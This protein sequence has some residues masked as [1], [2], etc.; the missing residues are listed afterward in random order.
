M[1]S[2]GFPQEFDSSA[3]RADEEILFQSDAFIRRSIRLSPRCEIVCDALPEDGMEIQFFRWKVDSS[4]D[5]A[6]FAFSG[7]STG[8]LSDPRMGTII[9]RGLDSETP[10]LWNPR[11][12]VVGQ[13]DR[14]SRLSIAEG[15]EIESWWELSGPPALHLQLSAPGDA[16]VYWPM[17]VFGDDSPTKVSD[18]VKLGDIERQRLIKSDWFDAA[19]VADLWAYFVDGGVYDP[20]DSGHGRVRC[21]QCAFAWW[22]YLMGLHRMTM[23]PHYRAFA[24]AVAWSVCVDLGDADS[25]RHGFWH[26]EP[27]VHSGLLWDGVR[28]LLSEYELAPHPDLLDAAH[29][30][31]EFAVENLTDDLEGGSLWFLH[32]SVE[33]SRR[34]HIRSPVI[35]RSDDNSLCLNT[36]VQALC[37]L[38]RINRLAP[39]DGPFRGEQQ[40]AMSALEAAL[41]LAADGVLVTLFARLLPWLIECKV[42]HS[43]GERLFRF[44]AYR[45]LPRALWWVRGRARCLVLPGG[46]VDRD[47]GRTLLS[48]EYL[49]INLKHLVELQGLEPQPWLREVIA[50]GV[51]FAASLDFERALE[52]HPIWAEWVDVLEICAGGSSDVDRATECVVSALGGKTLDAF[53]AS[54][55]VQ[56]V[57]ESS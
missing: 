13:T 34:L 31:T 56:R 41:A 45:L 12:L 2:V 42:P 43:F 27:E 47:I 15:H 28:L 24:R 49:V 6:S 16:T 46:Y 51:R 10:T 22:S 8:M 53:C 5:P 50:D 9:T 52:R 54:A 1:M 32:D 40:R 36:H 38:V 7:E 17:V 21:Q 55:G 4:A 44:L 29:G 35:G 20:R 3:R 30:A 39:D 57:E 23:K 33:G 48:D 11:G 14:H 25:L 19:S 18:L 37:M 26:S